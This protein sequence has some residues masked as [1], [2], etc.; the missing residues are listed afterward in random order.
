MGLGIALAH[1]LE[2]PVVRCGCREVGLGNLLVRPNRFYTSERGLFTLDLSILRYGKDL[3][4]T[5][6]SGGTPKGAEALHGSLYL[7]GNKNGEFEKDSD[8]LFSG[9]FRRGLA[10]NVFYSPE[11]TRAARERKVFG[12]EWPAHIANVQQSEEFFQL[13]DGVHHIEQIR[14]KIPG[15]AVIVE[16]SVEDH[17]QTAPDHR[18]IR[19]Q[20]EGFRNAGVRWIRLNPD[21]HYIERVLGRRPPR[22]IQNLAGKK[23]EPSAIVPA[24]E[25]S[26]G[27]GGPT[28]AEAMAAAACELADRVRTKRWSPALSSVLNP[29]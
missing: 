29:G 17:V 9:I 4:L 16:G 11:L 8:F 18:H 10:P 15:L 2:K 24:L 7:D 28:S 19:I 23:F 14:K 25:P 3:P 6:W 1:L 5:N 13:Q 26:P 21:S 22:L 12:S 27:E 20:Y